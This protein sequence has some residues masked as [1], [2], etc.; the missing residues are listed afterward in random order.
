MRKGR[1]INRLWLGAITIII[2]VGVT[3][4]VMAGVIGPQM[5]GGGGRT[6]TAEFANAQQLIAGDEVRVQ[7]VLEGQVSSVKLAPGGHATTVVMKVPDSAGPLYRDATA[8]VAWKTLLG[9]AFN[10]NLTRGTPGAGSLGSNTIPLSRTSNQVE[11]EDLISVDN[12]GAKTGLQTM[13]GQLAIAL[14]DPKPLAKALSTLAHVAPDLTTGVGALRG[15]VPD[16]DLRALVSS[17]ARTLQALNAPADALRGFVQGAAG[18][19]AVTAA[20]AADVKRALDQATPA[21]QQTRVTFS[22]L[23]A[24][25]DAA[26]PV[27]RTLSGSASQVGP[28]LRD[29]Y[30][31][32]TGARSLLNRA[33]PLL[34]ALPP[35]LR[36]L[37]S[38]ARGG[39]PLLNG[40][41]PS[42]DSLQQT[43]LPYLNTIDPATQHTTAE[44]IGPT[45]EA[46]GPDIA[47]QE[48]QN[49]HFIRFPATAGSSPFYLPCQ[50]YAG[51]PSS[52]QLVACSSLQTIFSA[53]LNYNPVQSLLGATSSTPTV[54]LRLHNRSAQ[55][56]ATV[57]SAVRSGLASGLSGNGGGR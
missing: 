5:F 23:R 42:V 53:F 44:M 54:P 36:S 30:P 32:V 39:L 27:L 48:D 57:L 45:T 20:R 19:V 37:A 31:T 15:V 29:L 56:V 49:G 40:V 25:L 7:G 6:V 11:L 28:T 22:E 43:V 51:N 26:N 46:L 13:P 41:Q 17:S 3:A 10:V 4:G 35:A 47:G 55:G 8:T 2:V 1:E 9:G 14:H 21:L 16:S 34:R 38:A 24:T 12:G 33:T 52:S 50:I 18:T